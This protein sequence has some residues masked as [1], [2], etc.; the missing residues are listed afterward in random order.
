MTKLFKLFELH[1]L[2]FDVKFINGLPV[3]IFVPNVQI[4][5]F[6]TTEKSLIRQEHIVSVENAKGLLITEKGIRY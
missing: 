4:S 2:D 6:G 5:D 3:E 1:S